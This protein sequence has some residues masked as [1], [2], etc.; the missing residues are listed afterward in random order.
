[1]K[2]PKLVFFLLTILLTHVSTS[3]VQWYQNQDANTPERGGTSAVQV[4]AF[5]SSSFI[6]TYLWSVDGDEN[7]W[8]ISKSHINGT[9]QR[10]IFLQGIGS[11]VEVKIGKNYSLYILKRSY[12]IGTN[13]N[14][15]VYKLDSNLVVRLQRSI[16]IPNNFNIVSLNA[17]EV[18]NAGYVYAAGD[19]HYPQGN[20]YSPASYVVKMDK[21]L[22]RKWIK[23]DLQETSFSRL[24]VDRNGS[25]LVIED[26]YSFYPN[27]K[28]KKIHRNGNYTNTITM[29]TDPERYS[30]YSKLDK[31]DNLLI[32]GGKTAGDAAQAVY[33]IKLLRNSGAVLFRK[34]HFTAAASQL[35]DL[36]LDKY[37]NLFSLVT[38]Y[39]ADGSQES[40]VSRI[41]SGNGKIIWNKSLPYENDS[42]SLLKL[43]INQDDKF[44]AVGEKRSNT[45]FSKGFALRMNKNGQIDSRFSSP[46]SVSFSRSHWLMDGIIDKTETLIAIGNTSDFDTT[47]YSSSYFRSFAV[48]VGRHRTMGCD[49]NEIPGIETITFSEEINKANKLPVSISQPV[50]YPNPAHNQLFV[51]NINTADYNGIYIYNMHGAIILQQTVKGSTAQFDVSNLPGGMYLLTLRSAVSLKEIKIKFLVKH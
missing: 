27:I 2:T 4:Q 35:N 38:M 29:Q 32:Y 34:T 46:D 23:M 11:S 40:R 8:K 6:A 48:K 37:N 1:M 12:P 25:V 3:Q 21:N 28:V 42:T 22:Q 18:D 30:L 41:N 10:H 19:G 33:L 44:Y 24:H 51:S 17:F 43:V 36:Q 15:V 50:A 13:A 31:Q 9:E 7:I 49:E 26:H 20:S 39:Y 45:Y 47:T 16:S 14:F 5:T